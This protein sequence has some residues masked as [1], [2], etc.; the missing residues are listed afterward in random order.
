M[1]IH[2]SAFA[3]PHPQ[4]YVRIELRNF[5][6]PPHD[7]LTSLFSS[8]ISS[9]ALLDRMALT[10]ACAMPPA[11]QHG[12]QAKSE[13]YFIGDA[14]DLHLGVNFKPCLVFTCTKLVNT[15]LSITEHCWS[16]ILFGRGDNCQIKLFEYFNDKNILESDIRERH[17]M[18]MC[19]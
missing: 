2:L 8:F 6:Y 15:F 3:Y 5:V 19:S 1:F 4:M 12:S 16:T 18:L 7:N 11:T 17:L 14:W 13:I 10:L 9:D